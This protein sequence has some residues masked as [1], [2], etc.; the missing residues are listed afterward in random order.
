MTM[1]KII[2]APF[3]PDAMHGKRLLGLLGALCLSAT[4]AA[5]SGSADEE[6]GEVPAAEINDDPGPAGN[7]AGLAQVEQASS[8]AV[9]GKR[10]FLQCH[11]CHAI[12]PGGAAKIGPPLNE[13]MGRKAGTVAG[14]GYSSAMAQSDI[15]WTEQNLDAFLASPSGLIPN[16]SMGFAGITSADQRINLI[17][18]INHQNK[19]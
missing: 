10:L 5:C 6:S 17:A 2:A 15:I 11:S 8:A 13:V 7:E 18:Y 3:S 1:A 9:Q 16:T 4:I 14:F 12:E 19:K